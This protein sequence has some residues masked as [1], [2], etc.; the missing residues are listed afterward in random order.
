MG[1]RYDELRRQKD[2]RT[3]RTFTEEQLKE[4]DR[5]VIEAYKRV[6]AD[7]MKREEAENTQHINNA[8]KENAQGVMSFWL[9]VSVRILIEQFNWKPPKWKKARMTRTERYSNALIDKINEI[10]TKPRGFRE[11][12]E[13]TRELYGIEFSLEER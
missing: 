13:E 10:S 7:E 1:K 2:Q 9:A 12:S 4:H 6:H 11:Y 3:I 5:Q 8:W